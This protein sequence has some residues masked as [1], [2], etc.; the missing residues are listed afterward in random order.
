MKKKRY[1]ID[2]SMKIN[3]SSL[4]KERKSRVKNAINGYFCN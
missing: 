2:I 3:I 1:Y 4:F